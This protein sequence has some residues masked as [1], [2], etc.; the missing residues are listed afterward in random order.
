MSGEGLLEVFTRVAGAGGAGDDGPALE[1]A[2]GEMLE[3]ARAAWPDLAVGDAAFVRY[4]AERLPRERAAPDELSAVDAPGLYLACACATRDPRALELFQSTLWPEVLRALSRM[5]I[6]PALREE[7]LSKLREQL[8]FGEQDGAG[9]L[10]TG[11]RGRGT[12]RSWLQSVGVH[13]A[14]KVRRKE[15]PLV[16]IDQL[17]DDLPQ[18]QTDPEMAYLRGFYVEEFRNALGRAMRTLPKRSR[19]LLRQHYLDKMSLEALA[20]VHRVHRATAARWLADARDDVFSKTKEELAQAIHL[21]ASELE[22]VMSFVR[23]QS[24]FGVHITEVGDALRKR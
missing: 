6:D 17:A 16:S 18:D 8:F 10:I 23:K 5:G 19:N 13:Q 3:R 1:A 20:K 21:Q 11:Y 9:P 24:S 2:L 4:V 22:S 7:I 15:R 12:L 14:L